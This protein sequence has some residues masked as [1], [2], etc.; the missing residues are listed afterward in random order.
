MA[1]TVRG[2]GLPPRPPPTTYHRPRAAKSYP[3]IPMAESNP[4]MGDVQE[5]LPTDIMRKRERGKLKRRIE[6]VG[7]VQQQ[8]AGD[9]KKISESFPSADD[10]KEERVSPN[11]DTLSEQI[12]EKEKEETAT[13]STETDPHSPPKSTKV[14]SP[15]PERFKAWKVAPRYNL[16]RILGHGSYGEV[17]EA[18]DTWAECKVAIKRINRFFDQSCS[19]PSGKKDADK[20]APGRSGPCASIPKNPTGPA[21]KSSKLQDVDAKRI[22][23]EIYILRNIVHDQIIKLQDV[24]AVAS[25][26]NAFVEL[27]LVFEFVDTDLQKLILSPQY[28]TTEHI[29]TFL[30]QMLLGLKYIHSA[31]V[32]HR[33]MKPA[34]ILVNEDCSLKI[35]DFGLAR[36]VPE[37]HLDP[38]TMP[39]PVP[40]F[41]P[42]PQP[43]PQA[44]EVKRANSAEMKA[45]DC[46]TKDKQNVERRKALKSNQKSGVATKALAAKESSKSQ[47]SLPQSGP[48]IIKTPNQPEIL[49]DSSNPQKPNLKRQLTKHVVT[50]WY[51][52]PELILLQDY[53]SAVDMWSLGCIFAEL[54]SMEEESVKNFKDRAPLFPG[55]SCFPLSADKP[56]SYTDKLDQLNVIFDVIGTPSQEDVESLGE[57][58]QYLKRLSKKPPTDLERRYQGAPPE[59]L[60][61]LRSMLKFNPSKRINVDEALDHPYLAPVR[62]QRKEVLVDEPICLD[63]EDMRMSRE[64]LKTR[65]YEEVAYFATANISLYEADEEEDHDD[66]EATTTTEYYDIHSNTAGESN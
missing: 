4:T 3:P 49:V 52:A 41:H 48:K 58:K 39:P 56:T 23:R 65:I 10:A 42:D 25:D 61:L 15:I 2:P 9:A 17:A 12:V 50:R 51:R 43:N 21:N 47:I 1:S 66:K 27:Y 29:Q 34:N 59:A 36:V 28:L 19:T 18:Y 62:K 33:D 46:L 38:R 57:V 5:P 40:L 45:P 44:P 13:G 14:S 32:I 55:K 63:F 53:T 16:I 35:C 11:K 8:R 37:R 30:Y 54:L 6:E 22:L 26:D 24:V 7:Y 64:D 20:E 60:D 31:H